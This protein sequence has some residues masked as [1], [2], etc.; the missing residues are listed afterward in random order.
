VFVFVHRPY[1]RVGLLVLAGILILGIAVSRVYLGLHYPTDDLA[2]FLI[3]IAWALIARY[4]LS[5]IEARFEP[6]PA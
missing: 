5:G 1:L 2:G 3:G 4:A 6:V